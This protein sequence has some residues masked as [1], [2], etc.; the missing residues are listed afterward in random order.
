[1]HGWVEVTPPGFIFD[2]K[3]HRR[4]VA[5]LG[6]GRVAARTRD[7]ATTG[8]GTSATPELERRSPSG[9]W[10]RRRRCR[11]GQV[12]RLPAPAHAGVLPAQAQ[13]RGARRLVE[14]LGPHGLAIELRNRNW[15]DGE[16]RERTLDWYADR[17]VGVRRRRRAA[18]RQLPDH[19]A[20]STRSRTRGLAYMR[21]H[22]RNTKGYLT[23]QVGGGALR[24]AV[25]GR[26]ARG[27]RGP[28]ARTLAESAGEVHVAFNNNRG[29]DA[30][31]AAQRFRA[32]LGPGE[33]G[34]GRPGAASMSG[35]RGRLAR[36]AQ[37]EPDPLRAVVLLDAPAVGRGARPGRGPSRRRVMR[38]G[39]RGLMS[40]I[41]GR[42]RRRR[43]R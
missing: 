39:A 38:R 26:R 24:V 27:D 14:R 25:H 43:P 36:A 41:E 11:G 1:M 12:R 20:D 7:R 23:G 33:S 22:G 16:L 8:R 32:L 40:W 3:A 21:A 37:L 31:T 34:A 4:A 28:R 13:A 15:V 6:A 2:V 18:R 29:D 5:A 17:G 10:R 30:P 19:A 42:A 9:W 35:A